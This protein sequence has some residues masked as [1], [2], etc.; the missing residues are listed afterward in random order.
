M[1]EILHDK[2][3][4][5]LVRDPVLPGVRPLSDGRWIRVDEA[6]AE[7]MKYRRELVATRR[8]EVLF[9]GGP[10]ASDAV[11]ECLQ[12]ALKLMPA[13]GF[14]Y[15]QRHI[16]CPDQAEIDHEADSPLATLAKTV[17]EDIC[18]LDKQGDEH[19][20]IAAALCFPASWTLAEKA[21]R[22]L[23]RIHAPVGEYT[24][25]MTLRV[26]RMF[27][28]VH[29]SR[30]LWR[31]N[32]LGYASPELFTPRSECETQRNDLPLDVAPYIRAERQCILR[33]PQTR[34]I[35]FSIHSYMAKNAVSA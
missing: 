27:D 11:E 13:M 17:Q 25:D 19:V 12:E 15:T 22:S 5:D 2:I 10:E 16:F 35:V 26:Q 4:E 29:D 21:G 30:P 18:I 8:D 32:M 33:L 6:Y 23:S 7:Q 31:N 34:A 24:G 14:S 1:R 3:P 9:E 20:L 28:A